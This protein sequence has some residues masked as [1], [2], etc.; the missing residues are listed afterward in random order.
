MIR[1]QIS[2]HASPKDMIRIKKKLRVRRKIEGTTERPRLSIF[3]STKNFVAQIID[4]SSGRTLVSAS[5][6]KSDKGANKESAK[7]LGQQIASLA[8]KAKIGQVVFDR[9][10]YLYHGKIKAFADGAREAGLKF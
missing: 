5:T 7:E 6:L 9:N 3:R 1:I 2:K 8:L 4:D 10:G